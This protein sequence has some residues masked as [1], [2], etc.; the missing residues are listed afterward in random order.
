M[1]SSKIPAEELKPF[2]C[3]YLIDG[4]VYDVTVFAADWED[5]AERLRAIGHTGAVDGE[6]VFEATMPKADEP[7]VV[8]TDGR[9][10]H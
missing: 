3:S 4:H 10:L 8:S 9:K 5:C 7:L 2:T 6:Q 1:S